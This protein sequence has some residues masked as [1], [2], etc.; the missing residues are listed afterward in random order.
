MYRCEDFTNVPRSRRRAALELK[1]PI[2]SP[3]ERTGH[4][5]VWSGGSAMVWFWDEGAVGGGGAASLRERRP[6]GRRRP[7][8]PR[9]RVLPETMF[10][11]KKPD[12]VHLQA[13]REGFELQHWRAGVLADAIW[14]PEHP[15]DGQWSWFIDRQ[16]PDVQAVR[17]A[18]GARAPVAGSELAAEPWSV[19]LTP[20]EWVED[21]ERGLAWTCLLAMVLVIVWQEARI[22][23]V[24]HLNETAAMEL[25]RLQT[26][27]GP[28]LEA[29]NELLRLRQT[30]QALLNLL[31]EPSQA[32]IMSLVD[33][34]IPNAKAKFREWRFQRGELRVVV[35]DPDPDPIEYVRSF[36]A[37][38]LFAQ[39]RAEPGRGENRIVITLKVKG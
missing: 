11:P 17:V 28:L 24:R 14:F 4:H 13:C 22:F 5:C 29:R 21:N 15:D 26:E 8:P 30:N 27:L 2:W 10:Y 23:N 19:P 6:A 9:F 12:G 31:R 1:L 25:T 34:A 38:P 37:V 18:D 16:G 3:F 36:E 20:R 7:S 33:G 35:E 32:R 39:V